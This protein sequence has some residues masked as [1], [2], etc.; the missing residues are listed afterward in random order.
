MVRWNTVV[1]VILD[2][3]QAN[4]SEKLLDFEM[5]AVLELINLQRFMPQ[6]VIAFD[7]EFSLE[8]VQKTRYEVQA[9][10]SVKKST[11]CE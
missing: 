8:F 2:K 1:I 3:R 5:L 9:L 7:L 10:Y 4:L 6:K 11:I